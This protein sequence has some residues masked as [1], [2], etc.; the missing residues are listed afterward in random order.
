MDER[1][2]QQVATESLAKEGKYLTFAL[3]KVEYGL[4]I[5]DVKEIIG[6]MEITQVPNV[7]D[8]VAGVINLRGKVIPVIEIRSKFGMEKIEYTKETCIVVIN[9]DEN[10]M[11]IIIDQVKDVLD[12][13]QEN[14][15]PPPN[16]SKEIKSEYILG[17]GKV[18]KELKVLLNIKK[19]L[20]EDLQIIDEVSE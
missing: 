3:G 5:L 17:M 7:P 14:I 16:F 12:I 9:I 4:E 10:L 6:I 8:Y 11:G 1:E 18:H 19:I 15:E 20:S 2:T 13:S